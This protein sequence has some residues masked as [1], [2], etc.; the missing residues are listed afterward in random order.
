MKIL[1]LIVALLLMSNAYAEEV[2]KQDFHARERQEL[3]KP[4]NNR[5]LLKMKEPKQNLKTGCHFYGNSMVCEKSN[6]RLY[7]NSMVCD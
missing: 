7:G 4:N 3:L 6:C 1:I 5:L 2:I